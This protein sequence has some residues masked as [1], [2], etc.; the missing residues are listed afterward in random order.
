MFA[1]FRLQTANGERSAEL[2]GWFDSG[3]SVLIAAE[4]LDDSTTLLLCRSTQVIRED[5]GGGVPP[6]SDAG[7][8]SHASVIIRTGR[9]IQ[10]DRF[11]EYAAA[12][13]VWAEPLGLAEW[14]T[15]DREEVIL[16]MNARLEKM[17]LGEMMRPVCIG[18]AQIGPK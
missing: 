15:V 12:D 6:P 5:C 9:I 13:M 4:L 18:M 7:R 3:E 17:Y 8:I 2:S 14:E 16:K 1:P 10:N 11:A